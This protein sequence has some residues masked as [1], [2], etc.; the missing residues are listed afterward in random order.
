MIA[1]FCV[2]VPVVKVVSVV[3]VLDSFMGAIGRAVFVVTD[4]V[5]GRIVM[6]VVVIAVFCV[7]VPVVKV[8]SVV[9]VLDSF[10]GAI[11]RAVFVVVLV[12]GVF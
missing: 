7:A 2:A 4:A 10:M 9:A 12:D 11:G 6:L 5:L 8:V 3:A 1:V